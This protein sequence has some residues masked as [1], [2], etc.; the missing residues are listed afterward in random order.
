MC[1]NLILEFPLLSKSYPH[2]REK[3]L[4]RDLPGSQKK[5]VLKRLRQRPQPFP[6]SLHRA[7]TWWW[8]P[9]KG[10]LGTIV[11]GRDSRPDSKFESQ[12]PHS[13][14]RRHETFGMLE[15]RSC[16]ALGPHRF[17]RTPV[18]SSICIDSDRASLLFALL[19]NL[20]PSHCCLYPTTGNALH[21]STYYLG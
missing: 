14:P 21:T 3:Q 17:V 4:P 6:A 2:P 19:L 20:L 18:S 12:R 13:S 16:L 8:K 5:L 7:R 15:V 9:N 11:S 10:V 1:R